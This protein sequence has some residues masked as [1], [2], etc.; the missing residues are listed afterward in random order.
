MLIS[1]TFSKP[2]TVG[3]KHK[4]HTR[5]R[6][7]VTFLGHGLESSQFNVGK[8]LVNSFENK[9]FDN[10]YGFVAFVALTGV[11]KILPSI[12]SSRDKF[13]N[14][15]FYV[16]VDNK[17]TSK[18]ALE[19][20]LYNEI[21]IY[22]YHRD[23]DYITYHP[24]LFLFEGEKF[25]RVII[26]S[27][28]LTSSGF[29]A[30]IEASIQLD[31][32]TKT[33]KQ[34]IKLIREIKEYYKDLIELSNTHTRKLT[35][36][37]IDEYEE[38][39]L[40]YKQFFSNKKEESQPTDGE[41]GNK[42]TKKVKLPDVD[43]TDGFDPKDTPDYDKNVKA[44]QN[45]YDNF[46][47]FLERYIVYKRDVRSSGVV[48]KTTDDKELLRWYFRMK[49][50]IRNEAMPDDLLLRLIDVDFPVGDGWEKTSMM[51]WEKRFKEMLAYKREFNPDS[52]I[53]HVPQFK[54]KS[55]PHY[56]IGSWCAQQKQRRKGNQTPLWSDYEEERMNSVNF[57]WEVP[58]LGSEPDD[59]GWYEK[60]LELESYYKDKNNFKS[61]PHQHTK[62][63]KWLN[64]Q[65]TLK[66]TGSRGKVKK[67]LNPL[68]TELLGEVLSKN[69][70]D[71]EW[72]KQKEREAIE[73]LAE[74]FIKNQDP[75]ELEKLSKDERKKYQD[76]V[77]Q[78]RYR[79]KKWDDT[80][81]LILI[82][83]GMELPK[84]EESQ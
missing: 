17:G 65:I 8:Q 72:Q 23:E 3:G 79:S 78:A 80:K 61:I 70:V 28:N 48:T 51:I 49:E 50:L 1:A 36:E 22:I 60:L 76:R 15:R 38:A 44:T 71:W 53:T 11:D 69:G 54:E 47:Y 83:A 5:Q 9:Y 12:K 43:L 55:H 64:E 6:M 82:N 45:D 35:R 77:S 18:E 37:L 30:N 24:K 74:E 34:G 4:E 31:F 68:R 21:E 14:L 46:D 26:G 13:K 39:D 66:L 81:R 57:L 40:L 27:S 42:K 67:F 32:N 84:K 19:K 33:D 2:E 59:E 58:N 73:N 16:G 75:K 10:F 63:G 20:L 52:E 25:S 29:I 7:Q 41:N 62:I 56:S